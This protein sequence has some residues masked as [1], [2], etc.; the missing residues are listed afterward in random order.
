VLEISTELRRSMPIT[1]HIGVCLSYPW[2]DKFPRCHCHHHKIKTVGELQDYCAQELP[3]SHVPR[4]CCHCEV[5]QTLKRMGCAMPNSCRV[6]ALAVLDELP[7][8]W[9]PRTP[10]NPMSIKE[11]AVSAESSWDENTLGFNPDVKLTCLRDGFRVL[12]NGKNCH[13]SQ[14]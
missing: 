1:Y 8:K 6:A 4:K 5:C 7:P 9:D 13:T 14:L 12:K 2:N 11:W 10:E 3:E